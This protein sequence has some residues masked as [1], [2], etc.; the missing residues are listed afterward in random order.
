MS[1]APDPPAGW[2]LFRHPAPEPR[3]SGTGGR[4]PHPSLR[5][6]LAHAQETIA[7]H[8]RALRERQVRHA[9]YMR[10]LLE[11]VDVERLPPRA[12]HL[13]WV[14]DSGGCLPPAAAYWLEG[15]LAEV[16]RAR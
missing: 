5:D 6:L 8:D 2:E 9:R 12:Q 1:E 13:L 4:E 14:L 16:R 15:E 3:L 11:G 7:A 10:D